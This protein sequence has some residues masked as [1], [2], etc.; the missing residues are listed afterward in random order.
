MEMEEITV[1]AGTN[2]PGS[3]T[4]SIARQY[5]R[6]LQ[7]YSVST[8]LLS[9]EGLDLNRRTE[10]LKEIEDTLIIPVQKFIFILPEYNGSFSGAV[11]TFID[12]TRYKE[13]W[14]FKK[15]LLTGVAEGKGGNLRGLE[16]FTGVLHFLKIVVHPNKL[17]ISSVRQLVNAQGEI[18]DEQTLRLIRQQIEEFLAL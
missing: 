15:A 10:Q 11:K 13:C 18:T 2:R 12:L 3:R 14:Y 16:H 4:L 9:L 7:D 1:I 8:H 6:L 17:P 5:I